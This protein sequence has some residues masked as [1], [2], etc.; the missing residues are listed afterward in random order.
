MTLKM[1]E[2]SET[3]RQMGLEDDD[4]TYEPP[5]PALFQESG[6]PCFWLVTWDPSYADTFHKLVR[7][8][9]EA[10]QALRDVIIH[11]YL[12]PDEDEDN[13]NEDD[14]EDRAMEREMM[15]RAS[16]RQLRVYMDGVDGDVSFG[17]QRVQVGMASWL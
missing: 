7:T 16:L 11:E 10:L 4:E 2:L 17:W 6:E 12:N 9:R 5:L 8:K 3:I 1:M 14:V 15:Q 13:L